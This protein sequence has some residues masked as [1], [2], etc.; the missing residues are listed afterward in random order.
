MYDCVLRDYFHVCCANEDFA[1]A[2]DT[3]G[4]GSIIKGI[5]KGCL[6]LS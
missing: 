1:R 6:I 5:I 2:N 3:E 4:V